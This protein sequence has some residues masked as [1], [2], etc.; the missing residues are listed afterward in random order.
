MPSQVHTHTHI[1]TVIAFENEHTKIQTAKGRSQREMAAQNKTGNGHTRDDHGQILDEVGSH[2]TKI[3]LLQH[4]GFQLTNT[5]KVQVREGVIELLEG[6]MWHVTIMERGKRR[7]RMVLC[8]QK[9]SSGSEAETS[10]KRRVLVKKRPCQQ[11]PTSCVELAATSGVATTKIAGLE[12][13]SV[14]SPRHGI[15]GCSRSTGPC[16]W[17][18][19]MWAPVVQY[20]DTPTRKT[21]HAYEHTLRES[22]SCKDMQQACTWC[23]NKLPT[24]GKEFAGRASFSGR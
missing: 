22:N 19:H 1:R 3:G 4:D 5:T 6:W 23:E 9:K 17:D 16:V 8:Q 15:Q 7:E 11:R 20:M 10:T 14:Q 21:M 12:S 24:S 13:G 2:S 18:P